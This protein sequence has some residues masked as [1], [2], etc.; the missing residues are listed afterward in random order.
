MVEESICSTLA[1]SS[2][3]GCSRSP[4]FARTNWSHVRLRNPVKP[5]RL[6]VATLSIMAFHVMSAQNAVRDP[7]RA[8]LVT[9]DLPNFW[10]AYDRAQHVAS[11]DERARIYLETYLRPGSAGLHDWTKLRL[12]SGYGLVPVL[13]AKGW[14]E[15]RLR[16]G[17]S[18]T[19]SEKVRLQRDTAGM[20]DLLAGYNLDA[21]V[22]RRPRFFA[23]IRPV[24]L[25]VDTARAVKDAIRRAYHR[26]ADLYPAAA[27]PP[28]YFLVGQLTSGGTVSDAGQLV[29][30]EMH[31]RTPDTPA[32][33]LSPWERQVVG[34]IDA[35]PGIV[36][37]EL[38]HSEAAL[39]R[40]GVQQNE[41]KGTLLAQALDEGCAS[42]LGQLI[43]AGAIV[44]ANAYGMAHEAELWREFQGEMN[45]TDTHNW[46]YQG[47]KAKGR[48]ADLG[49][50]VGSRI[51]QSYYEHAKDKHTAVAEILR[52][53]DPV[54]FVRRSDYA[55]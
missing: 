22:E 23:A 43:S 19:D 51:C 18:F 14:S 41:G 9:S 42:F 1:T 47:D 36:A 15:E 13:V 46:L 32:D 4:S 50:F 39:A 2:A 24:T 34:G 3:A 45:G 26:L 53:S 30:V 55:P 35:L 5:K 49:Y 44:N 12:R 38:I 21:A 16:S 20:G 25:A 52:M 54:G 7:D 28:V 6:I 27:F 29:G 33:E 37:H 10:L 40:S 17:R 31:A 8:L 11:R 48:P